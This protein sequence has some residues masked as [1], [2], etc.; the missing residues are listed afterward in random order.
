MDTTVSRLFSGIFECPDC[1]VEFKVDRATE[2][3]LFCEQ[4]GGDLES[5]EA[6]DVE[7]ED[8][9]DGDEEAAA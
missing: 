1:E 2:D 3:D 4:C 8:D 6:S 9:E 7:V 5:S